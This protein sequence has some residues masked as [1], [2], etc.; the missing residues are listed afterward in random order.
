VSIRSSATGWKILYHSRSVDGVDIAVSG[1]VIIPDGEPPVTGRTVIA[2]GPGTVGLAD[3]CASST[4]GGNLPLPSAL[5]ESWLEAGYVIAVTDYEGLGTPGPHPYGVGESE[6]R[7]ILDIARAA[8]GLPGSGASGQVVL[9]GHSQG[10]HAAFF[11]ADIAADYAPELVVIGTV[12]QAPVISLVNV[13]RL[14]PDSPQFAGFLV[15]FV[16]GF[17]AAYPEQARLS[18]VMNEHGIDES[19]IVE[20]ACGDAVLDKFAQTDI[21]TLLVQNPVDVPAW[22]TLLESNSLG[23]GRFTTPLLLTKGDAD[24]VLPKAFTDIFVDGLC[25]AGD[26]VDYLTY[27]GATHNSVIDVSVDDVTAW[28][29]AR[30]SGAPATSTC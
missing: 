22:L 24:G 19:S 8:I 28:I 10:G 30:V 16:R 6:G 12:A 21:E 14:G 11:A 26:N 9:F 17:S 3:Q 4:H 25:A 7:G 27:S 5:L 18:A 1:V 2:V 20:E 15:M 13:M 23:G 29:A